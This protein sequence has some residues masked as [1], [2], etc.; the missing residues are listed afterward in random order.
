MKEQREDPKTHM[1]END[2][3][4]YENDN[5]QRIFNLLMSDP[6]LSL[7]VQN[8]SSRSFNESLQNFYASFPQS[9]MSI[10]CTTR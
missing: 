3:E 1:Y 8:V 6:K 10:A 4:Q 5:E 2:N 9:S 7:M